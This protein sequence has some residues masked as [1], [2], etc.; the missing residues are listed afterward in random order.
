MSHFFAYL[1]KMKFIKRWGLMRNVREENIQEHSLQ[2]AMIA[3]SLALIKNKLYGGELDPYRV[4]LLAVYHEASEVIT[5]DLATPI[6]Y[7]NPEIKKAYKDI[8]QIANQRLF[9]MLPDELKDEFSSVFFSIPED[10]DH[11]LIVKE[12]DK[13]CAYLKC[14]EELKAGNQEFSKAERAIAK[15]ISQMEGPEV[16]YFMDKFVPSFHLTL[17]ELN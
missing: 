8:E 6:K 7:F 17:D 9:S 2:V 14:I 15:D 13:I 16:K 11:R 3:H 1:S 12:A 4:L 10:N 5:G